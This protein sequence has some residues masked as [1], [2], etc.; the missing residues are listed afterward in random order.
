MPLLFLLSSSSFVDELKSDI[1]DIQILPK[2]F[3]SKMLYFQ[4]QSQFA[5][6][7]LI[8][9]V[10]YGVIIDFIT[11]LNKYRASIYFQNIQYKML[12]DSIFQFENRRKTVKQVHSR[13]THNSFG[14]GGSGNMGLK[15]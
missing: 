8:V 2:L 9:K 13:C 12:L 7:S 10:K 4:G 15:R 11:L 5:S 3:F 14:T 1:D 6:P